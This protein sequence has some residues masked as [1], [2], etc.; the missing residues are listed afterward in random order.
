MVELVG[1]GSE[2]DLDQSSS[3]E[4]HFSKDSGEVAGLKGGVVDEDGLVLVARLLVV[5][6]RKSFWVCK[7][8]DRF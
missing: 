8:I 1:V 2:M 4:E 7:L 3:R 6:G 5:F